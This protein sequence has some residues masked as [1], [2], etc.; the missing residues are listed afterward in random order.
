MPEKKKIMGI[1]DCERKGNVVRFTIGDVTENYHGDDWDDKYYAS[2]AGSV[3]SE[4]VDHYV[5]IAFPFDCDVFEPDEDNV[6]RDDM[7][8]RLVPCLVVL[9]NKVR[10]NRGYYYYSYSS[11]M[12]AGEPVI[13]FYFGDV[14]DEEELKTEFDA[15]TMI[16]RIKVNYEL[17]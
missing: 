13:K 2:N 4:Y 14:I 11:L 9:P 3:Y 15:L 1:I 10:K 16:Q 8:A 5:D 17:V 7:K 6:S 12:Q